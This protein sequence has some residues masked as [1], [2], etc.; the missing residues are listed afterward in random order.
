VGDRGAEELRED[1]LVY[2]AVLRNLH[3]RGEAA[4]H[5]SQEFREANPSIEWRKVAGLRDIISHEYFGIDDEVI[6]DVVSVKVPQ[7]A[8]APETLL[9]SGE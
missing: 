4:K 6:W 2:D 8:S 1:E 7:L 5:V 3:V 9:G